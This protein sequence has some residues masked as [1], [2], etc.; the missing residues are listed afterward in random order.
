MATSKYVNMLQAT[1]WR[2]RRVCRSRYVCSQSYLDPVANCMYCWMAGQ[3]PLLNDI[4]TA[5]LRQPSCSNVVQEAR[6][7]A[8][9]LL[10]QRSATAVYNPLVCHEGATYV[11][12][13]R[14]TPT[15]GELHHG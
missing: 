11:L 7:R 3:L 8:D 4:M 9:W 15:H 12:T 6:S 10:Q 5:S 14:H 2:H 1:R 13:E